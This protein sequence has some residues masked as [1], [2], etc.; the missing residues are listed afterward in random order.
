MANYLSHEYLNNDL[1]EVKKK[2][3]KEITVQDVKELAKKMYLDSVFF[4]EGS[5]SN[6]EKKS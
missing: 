5:R 2:K 3:I 1:L 4:L 6:A